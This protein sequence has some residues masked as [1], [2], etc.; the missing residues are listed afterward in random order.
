MSLPA[1]P[2]LSDAAPD[3]ATVGPAGNEILT[4]ATALV[5]TVLLLAEGVTIVR[6]HGLVTAHMFIGMVLIPP[7]L[8]KLGSTGWRFARYYTGSRPYREKGPPPLPLRVL[9]PLL[10]VMTVAVFASGVLLLLLGH[11]NRLLLEVHK[12]AFIVWGVTF[13]VHFLAHAQRVL[14]SLRVDWGAPRRAAVPGAG[15]RG[16]LVAAAV[17]G[18]AA[19]ALALLSTIEGW[20]A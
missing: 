14:R 4:S 20:R 5:L 19:L 16:L 17:G 18:G 12:V 10:V 6:M 11:K 1:A 9:A 13:A 2:V 8:L 15:V 7:V 3:A